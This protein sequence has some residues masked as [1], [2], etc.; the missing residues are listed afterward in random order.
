MTKEELQ[1][2][3]PSQ[4][5]QIIA[6]ERIRISSYMTF[7]DTS[8]VQVLSAIEAGIPFGGVLREELHVA[9]ATRVSTRA[10]TIKAELDRLLGLK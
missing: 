8:P 7:Y 5:E 1:Q 6:E 10:Q 9:Q 2:A 3:Y 4:V